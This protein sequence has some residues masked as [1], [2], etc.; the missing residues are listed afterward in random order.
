MSERS[1]YQSCS[2]AVVS[3]YAAQK[4]RTFFCDL[5][6]Y[7]RMSSWTASLMLMA[8]LADVSKKGQPILLA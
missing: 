8:S 6:I 7:L 2:V 1:A 3:A 4:F 5:V